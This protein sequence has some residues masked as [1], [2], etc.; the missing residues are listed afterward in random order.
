MSKLILIANPGSASRKY[1]LYDG[2]ELAAQLHFE[3][4]GKKVVCT[5]K[6]ADGKK[7]KIT[8]EVK[9]LNDAIEAV[10]GILREEQY[11]GKQHRLEAVVV[12]MAAPGEYFA[13]HQIVDAR[14]MKELKKAEKRNPIHVPTTANEIR[15]IKVI[16]PDV[17][18]ISISDSAFHASKP[19]MMKYYSFD[20]VLADKTEIKRF[21]YHGLSYAYIA[22]HM[23]KEGI[24]PHK[25]VAMH[26]GSGASV[27]AILD[28]GAMDNSMGYTPLEGLT[29]ATRVG[30]MDVGAALALKD[31]LKIKS[32]EEFLLYLNKQAGLKGLSGKTDDM[33][34][35]IELR[36]RGDLRGTMAHA[37]F[38][39]RVQAYVGQMA[40][41]LGGVDALV[42]AGTIGER[43]SEI[44]HFVMQKMAYLGF[45]L[46]EAK[47]E[48]PEFK[49]GC[50]L[51][52][53]TDSKPIY[54]VTTDESAQMI[55]EAKQLLGE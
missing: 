4:E 35:I 17:K 6:G 55:F 33:R 37:I 12:R 41:A 52:S 28:G 19:E 42:F 16:F 40:A 32:D 14:Y 53:A 8:P 27:S 3:Y 50:A 1:A 43:S 29:M 46:D 9:D 2:E 31:A 47:N 34:E 5:V 48:A 36:D 13:K 15:G 26:L 20:M 23:R 18:I 54:V 44:R 45:S 22:R 24:L 7:H 21:G 10:P 51:I 38:V 25:L 39:Y 30:A 49:N 11:L